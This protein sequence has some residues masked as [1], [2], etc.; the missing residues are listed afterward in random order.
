MQT[1]QSTKV[2]PKGYYAKFVRRYKTTPK[3]TLKIMLKAPPSTPILN[4]MD[5]VMKLANTQLGEPW[6][7]KPATCKMEDMLLEAQELQTCCP[8][9]NSTRLKNDDMDLL[10]D[11][12]DWNLLLL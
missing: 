2:Q 8:S 6:P 1:R 9:S 7:P 11:S 12:I 4:T 10:I 5:E 3:I